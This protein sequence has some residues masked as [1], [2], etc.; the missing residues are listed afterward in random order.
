MWRWCVVVCAM[1]CAGAP[2]QP[3]APLSLDG[4]PAF[5]NGYFITEP[6]VFFG[7]NDL[8]QIVLTTQPDSCATDTAFEAAVDRSSAPAAQAATWADSYPDDHWRVYLYLRV[9]DASK[10]LT[11][12]ELVGLPW[13]EEFSLPDQAYA[14]LLHFHTPFDEPYYSLETAF[15]DYVHEWFSDD[16]RVTLTEHVA[17]TSIAGTFP[18]V[19]SDVSNGLHVGELLIDFDVPHCAALQ[20]DTKTGSTKAP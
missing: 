11:G 20:P 15:E 16:G 5:T 18:T 7:I 13:N 8:V 10:D 3:G 17:D 1:G 12:T 19:A 2:T 4:M 9:S 6:G 14:S